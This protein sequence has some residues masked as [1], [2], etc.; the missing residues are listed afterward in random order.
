M[1]LVGGVGGGDCTGLGA[2][3]GE[4]KLGVPPPIKIRRCSIWSLVRQAETESGVKIVDSPRVELP[5]DISN[6]KFSRIKS[7]GMAVEKNVERTPPS[8][9][10]S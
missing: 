8:V 5:Y 6:M 10:K 7:H 1:N 2:E 9:G 3:V 4:S